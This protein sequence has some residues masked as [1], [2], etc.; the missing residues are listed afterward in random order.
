MTEAEARRWCRCLGAEVL[1]YAHHGRTLYA[2]K[3]KGFHEAWDERLEVA[4][5]HLDS[6]VAHFLEHASHGPTG[7][8]LDPLRAGREQFLSR[9]LAA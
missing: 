5:E 1:P 9:S 6:N 7:A 8:R 2:V 3:V 4:V